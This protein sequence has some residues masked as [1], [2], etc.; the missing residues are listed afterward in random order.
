MFSQEHAAAGIDRAGMPLNW[1]VAAIS[2][3]SLSCF[4]LL[5][6]G[7]GRG[8]GAQFGCAEL[9]DHFHRVA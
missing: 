8:S 6:S 9:F 4:F 1:K 7:R 5:P 2:W 3:F